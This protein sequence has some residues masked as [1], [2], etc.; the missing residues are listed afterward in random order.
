MIASSITREMF[1][2][3]YA[4]VFAGD[5]RWQ[6]LATPTGNTFAWDADSTYV[7]KPPYFDGMGMD[8]APVAD[9]SRCPGAGQ[10]GRL[11]DHRPHQPGRLDQGGTRPPRST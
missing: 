3:D 11:G 7:R 2:A 6:N 8:P 9:I 5:E 4:D 1:T 10:A